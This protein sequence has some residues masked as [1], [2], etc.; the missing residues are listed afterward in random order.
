MSAEELDRVGVLGLVVERPAPEHVLSARAGCHASRV[1][2][3]RA[4][5]RDDEREVDRDAR[6]RQLRREAVAAERVRSARR[7]CAFDLEPSM[8]KRMT[9]T[10]GY[11]DGFDGVSGQ[12]TID[13]DTD[14]DAGS[15]DGLGALQPVAQFDSHWPTR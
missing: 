7:R 10:L 3:G 9:V 5:R 2:G 12:I 14:A 15:A 1:H 4:V 11:V 6:D 8:L 13:T